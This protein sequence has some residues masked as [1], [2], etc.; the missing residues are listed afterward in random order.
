MKSLDN[1][2]EDLFN[3]IRGRFPSITIGDENGKVTNDPLVARFFDFDYKAGDRN[4]GKVS[5][6]VS[7]EKL[8]IMY[9]TSFVEN[10]DDITRDDWYNFL[11]ELRIF[12]KKRLLQFD[13]R[14]ITK[15]NLLKV[16]KQIFEI[17]KCLEQ[18][19]N[20]YIK[21]LRWNNF[22]LSLGGGIGVSRKKLKELVIDSDFNILAMSKTSDGSFVPYSRRSGSRKSRLAWN[23]SAGIKYNYNA[24]MAFVFEYKHM[25]L[26]K[27]FCGE[28]T[29]YIDGKIKIRPK[30]STNIRVNTFLAGIR[31]NF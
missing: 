2:A 31:I 17:G 19:V 24:R 23:V 11:K 21:P 20:G 12:A 6:S 16:N 13:T 27:I 7:E 9:S 10:E 5:I 8:A 1:I 25:N 18:V 22:E 29:K 28:I 4:I 30:E 14:D 3:K 26:G 15:S